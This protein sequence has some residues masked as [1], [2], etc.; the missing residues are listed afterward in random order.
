MQGK[1]VGQDTYQNLVQAGVDFISLMHE[2][3]EEAG[4]EHEH[5]E[6]DNIRHRFAR[7]I[8][9]QISEQGGVC[10]RSTKL[11]ESNLS[12]MSAATSASVYVSITY[13]Y[14]LLSLL[15]VLLLLLF[16]SCCCSYCCC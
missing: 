14:M 5:E 3:E 2:E 16:C 11:V 6:R 13:L 7:S 8:S 4:M 12:V 1:C 10:L 9:R 15:L